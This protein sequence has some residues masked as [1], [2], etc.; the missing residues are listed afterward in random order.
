MVEGYRVAWC[1]AY[2]APDKRQYPNS[3]EWN[4]YQRVTADDTGR[5]LGDHGPITLCPDGTYVSG[6]CELTP[7]GS[8]V[9]R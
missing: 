5:Q 1:A 3:S 2:R 9:G 4:L 8:Y 7:N 6:Q